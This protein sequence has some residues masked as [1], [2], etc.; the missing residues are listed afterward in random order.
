VSLDGT[1]HVAGFFQFS[2][3]MRIN[4]TLSPQKTHTACTINKSLQRKAEN[5]QP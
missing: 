4:E 2:P 1:Q 3:L 5:L